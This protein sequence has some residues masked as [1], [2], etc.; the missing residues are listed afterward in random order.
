M[1]G[2]LREKG[3]TVTPLTL[4]DLSHDDQAVN[5]NITKDH[6]VL[7]SLLTCRNETSWMVLHQDE[8]WH[9]FSSKLL[10]PLEFLNNPIRSAYVVYKKN[11]A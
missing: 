7:I 3:F 2:F 11:W 6:V 10:E 4:C 9:N 8:V 5:W 1:V